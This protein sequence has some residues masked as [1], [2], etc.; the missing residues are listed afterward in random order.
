MRC[1]A[2]KAH[3]AMPAWRSKTAKT[4]GVIAAGSN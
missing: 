3:K 2:I 4:A 1:R